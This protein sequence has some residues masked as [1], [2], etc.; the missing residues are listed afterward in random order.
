M[1]A[2]GEK[3]K[4]MRKNKVENKKKYKKKKKKKFVKLFFW[5]GKK[6]SREFFRLL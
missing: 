3:L 4:N 1:E 6:L 5:N 2:F